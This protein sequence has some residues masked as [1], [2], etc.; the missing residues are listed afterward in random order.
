MID[1]YVLGIDHLYAK[2]VYR[3]L[4]VSV[5]RIMHQTRRVLLYILQSE[6]CNRR[7]SY[8][9]FW[10][11]GVQ[12][13]QW[14]SSREFTFMVPCPFWSWRYFKVV[15]LNFLLFSVIIMVPLYWLVWI[16]LIQICLWLVLF[17]DLLQSRSNFRFS[18][19]RWWKPKV[20]HSFLSNLWKLNNTYLISAICCIRAKYFNV[21]FMFSQFFNSCSDMHHWTSIRSRSCSL[22][23]DPIYK[24]EDIFF[25]QNSQSF[26]ICW[27]D[28]NY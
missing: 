25:T 18:K 9:K 26:V 13:L 6:I 1:R 11:V 16:S 14:P 12:Y 27:H 4:K 2:P 21:A 24:S 3:N 8:S 10:F 7:M 5:F 17:L 20:G 28:I 19:V 15:N 23:G 22:T